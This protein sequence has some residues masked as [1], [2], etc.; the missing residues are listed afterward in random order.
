MRNYKTTSL[1]ILLTCVVT[2]TVVAT[3]ITAINQGSSN[4]QRQ[5]NEQNAR[6]IE[7]RHRYPV[8]D[9]DAPEPAEPERRA[10]RKIKNGY[11][12]KSG[13][14]VK[15][16]SPRV[17]EESLESEWALHLPALPAAQSNAV[18]TGEILTSEAHLSNDKTGIY[19]EFTIRINEVLKG[20]DFGLHDGDTL[21]VDRSGGTV[22]YANGHKRLYSI[23]GQNMPRLGGSYVLFITASQQGHN[24]HILTGYELAGGKV[25]P[26][27]ES[28]SMSAYEGTDETSFLKA[29]HEAITQA[30]R[31]IPED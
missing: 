9:Y 12:D 13:F 8:V 11:Y 22:Q 23:A 26:L 6:L 27:D 29:V 28:N 2:V 18:I 7:R 21:T 25:S 19:S 20:A 5:K 15:D 1:L 17:D 4:E 31:P 10:A 14:A 30:S 16:P 3:K 24:Y